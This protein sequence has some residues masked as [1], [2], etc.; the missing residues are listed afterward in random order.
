MPTR[1]CGETAQF[2]GDWLRVCAH[3]RPPG[4]Q[5]EAIP[6]QR[7]VIGA[8]FC[9]PAELHGLRFSGFGATGQRA[10]RTAAPPAIAEQ[11]SG[12]AGVLLFK[13]VKC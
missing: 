9:G 11:A 6:A 8:P 7:L 3:R 4:G 13:V 5:W 12:V 1:N 10:G 2:A